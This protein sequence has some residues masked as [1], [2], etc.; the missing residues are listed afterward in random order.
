MDVRYVRSGFIENFLQKSLL[1][2]DAFNPLDDTE[3]GNVSAAHHDP[4]LIQR[5]FTHTGL[6]L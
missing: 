3:S 6:C 5:S 2:P 4:I 1:T